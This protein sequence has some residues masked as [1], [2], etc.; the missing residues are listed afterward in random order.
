MFKIKDLFKE[1]KKASLR[2]KNILILV[3]LFN[4]VSFFIGSLLI[5]LENPF[6]IQLRDWYYK[7]VLPTFETLYYIEELLKSGNLFQ[8]IIFTFLYNLFSGAFLSTTLPG[9]IPFI[10]VIFISFAVIFRGLV[11]GIAYYETFV[12]T[13]ESF[14]LFSILFIIVAIGTLFLEFGAYVF[15]AS[16][17]INIGLSII[18]PKRYFTDNRF[19]AFKKSLKDA[20]R[21]Y[22]IVSILLFLGAIWEMTGIFLIFYSK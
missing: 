21:I 18:F 20:L 3:V 14:N 15:S 10:G 9:I 4:I 16:A 7:E 22:I 1:A 5:A 12:K 19:E 11:I 17:G 2:I 8:A 13:L 6:A